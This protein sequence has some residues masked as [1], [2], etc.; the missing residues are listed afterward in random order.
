M[1][2]S[3]AVEHVRV[4]GNSVTCHRSKENNQQQCGQG[5]DTRVDHS[6]TNIGFSPPLCI[7][8]EIEIRDQNI[9]IVHV[10][11]GFVQRQNQQH[12]EWA[13]A[14]QTNQNNRQI[15]RESC[16]RFHFSHHQLS[17]FRACQAQRN[18]NR[19]QNDQEHN[20]G[21]CRRIA[22]FA[23]VTHTHNVNT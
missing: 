10:A 11:A 8:S 19:N 13:K 9:A 16:F 7:V 6:S 17:I 18:Q 2:Q 22:C 20:H 15:A 12:Y 4:S 3:H 14:E 5:N 1:Q 21:N 23:T